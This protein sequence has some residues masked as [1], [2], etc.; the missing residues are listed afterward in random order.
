V[1]RFA[2]GLLALLAIPAYLMTDGAGWWP[3]IAI[4][5]IGGVF[6]GG[7]LGILPSLFAA[8]VRSSGLALGYDGAFSVVGGL[9]P[10]VMLWLS[11]NCGPIAVGAV[12]AALAIIAIAALPRDGAKSRT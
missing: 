5:A 10:F 11:K 3:L 12:T 4:G 6:I 1:C 7:Y 8:N 9:G 2:L